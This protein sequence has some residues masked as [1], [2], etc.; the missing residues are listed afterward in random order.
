MAGGGQDARVQGEMQ[1]APA[2]RASLM[3][4][5]ESDSNTAS[6]PA[7][8][9]TMRA[10]YE[11]VVELHL[12]LD[13]SQELQ[14]NVL[15][16]QEG[17]F[18][19]L[20]ELAVMAAALL[21]GE[22]LI[23]RILL[24]AKQF[25]A[26]KRRLGGERYTITGDNNIIFTDRSQLKVYPQTAALLHPANPANRQMREAFR[27]LSADQRIVGMNAYN[28]DSDEAVAEIR[29]DQFSWFEIPRDII[30]ESPIREFT[31]RNVHLRIRSAAFDTGLRWRFAYDGQL[32][33]ASVDDEAF[34]KR[35]A[36]GE[37]FSYGDT[38]VSDLQVRQRWDAESGRFVD[39]EHRIVK[40]RKH[41]AAGD[42]SRQL[43]LFPERP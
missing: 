24:I 40:V 4:V 6:V 43:G 27:C 41:I 17:S 36:A 13:R 1:L 33:S 8:I 35:V 10:M 38:L 31:R 11:L 30:D 7:V 5:L 34:L 29:R 37:T 18:E 16:F 21:Q 9:E 28:L 12:A 3:S 32:T 39:F 26:V 20:I 25:F 19:I 42:R 2:E 23:S 14:V 15:P 22:G